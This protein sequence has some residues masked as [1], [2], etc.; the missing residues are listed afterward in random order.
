VDEKVADINMIRV[1]Y[2]GSAPIITDLVSG[3]IQVGFGTLPAIE[4]ALAL[5]AMRMIAI[6]EGKRSSVVPDLPTISETLLAPRRRRRGFPWQQSPPP[7]DRHGRWRN[8]RVSLLNAMRSVNVPPVST[9]TSHLATRI[10]PHAQ[11]DQFRDD[12]DAV[13]GEVPLQHCG[14]S[15]RS[16]AG[17]AKYFSFS[18]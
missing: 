8:G 1:S 12:C 6:A 17:I 11:M 7:M 9:S 5:G 4:P 10:L 16:S 18:L 2:R 14:V 13:I 15:L 3:D